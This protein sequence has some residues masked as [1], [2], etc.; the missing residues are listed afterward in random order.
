MACGDFS[1]DFPPAS[2]RHTIYIIKYNMYI[3]MI[4]AVCYDTHDAISD[5]QDAD[6]APHKMLSL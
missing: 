1:G 5:A 2:P 6:A 3:Y 4:H